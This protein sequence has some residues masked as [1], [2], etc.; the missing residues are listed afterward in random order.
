MIQW[1][2]VTTFSKLIKMIFLWYTQKNKRIL[3]ECNKKLAYMRNYYFSPISTELFFAPVP[4]VILTEYSFSSVSFSIRIEFFFFTFSD[5]FNRILIFSTFSVT[6]IELFF[7][8]VF[9]FIWISFET[10]GAIWKK[11]FLCGFF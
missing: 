9:L 4:S 3:F 8:S 10:F 7:T 6:W 1:K 5:Y 2:S 11:P